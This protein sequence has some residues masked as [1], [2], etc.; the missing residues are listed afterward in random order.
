MTFTFEDRVAVITGAAG[1]IGKAMAERFARAGMKLLL[2]D[3]DEALLAQTADTLR[4]TGTK[5]ET[6]KVDVAKPQA[7]DALADLA[8]DR[9][10]AVHLLCN[11][12]GVVPGNRHRPIW[13]YPPEDWNWAMDVNLIGVVNGLRAFVPRMLAQDARSHIVN[14]ASI[15]GL[16]SGARAPLYSVSKHAVVRATEALYSALQD[17]GAPIGVTLLCPGVVKTRIYESERNRPSALSASA[18]PED[19]APDGSAVMDVETVA[20]LTFAAIRDNIFY[21]LTT[22]DFDR[23]IAARFEAILARRNPQFP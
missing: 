20:E 4:A 6:L 8:F 19:G 3:V 13:E 22:S 7:V 2:S 10:G 1:G 17:R 14:T 12:A 15:A 5:V 11:N 16:I 21:L 9:F 18:T 23:H